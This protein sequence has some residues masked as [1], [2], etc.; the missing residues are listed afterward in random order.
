MVDSRRRLEMLGILVP[1]SFRSSRQFLV[2]RGGPKSCRTLLSPYRVELETE[3]PRDY[4][5]V[6]I[7]AL[8]CHQR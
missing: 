7:L 5:D 3:F 2:Y 6:A 4:R 8:A 1:S